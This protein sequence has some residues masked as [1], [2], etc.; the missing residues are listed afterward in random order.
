M[1]N[2]TFWLCRISHFQYHMSECK[3]QVSHAEITPGT[4]ICPAAVSEPGSRTTYT[5]CSTLGHTSCCGCNKEVVLKYCLKTR[6]VQLISSVFVCKLLDICQH[7]ILGNKF[8]TSYM[9]INSCD[10]PVCLGYNR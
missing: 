1:S 5:L 6:F 4:K 8:P 7:S 2:S 3:Y 10:R 9:I